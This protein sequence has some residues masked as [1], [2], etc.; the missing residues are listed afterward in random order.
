MSS[1]LPL[2]RP[3]HGGRR[4]RRRRS[5]LRTGLLLLVAAAMVAAGATFAYRAYTRTDREGAVRDAIQRYAAAWRRQ[6]Y[7]TL[8]RLTTPA[9]RSAIDEPSFAAAYRQALST[10]SGV[11][12]EVSLP[13]KLHG[14]Q[15]VAA[16]TVPTLRFGTQRG[17]VT[18][19][20]SGP[21]SQ[22]R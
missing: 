5:R 22:I 1:S 13:A 2:L 8:Y 6:D 14:E 10:A 15:A 12:V 20:A 17:A 16:V 7:A 19:R 3:A 4:R 18:L 9:V 21:T 11:R